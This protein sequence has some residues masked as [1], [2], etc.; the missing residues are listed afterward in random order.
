VLLLSLSLLLSVPTSK[1]KKCSYYTTSITTTR[2]QH[3]TDA[4]TISAIFTS[5][6]GEMPVTMD[7]IQEGGDRVGITNEKYNAPAHKQHMCRL[8]CCCDCGD[9]L[10]LHYII[11]S[12]LVIV[13]MCFQ[14]S[15]THMMYGGKIV[16][17]P[18]TTHVGQQQQQQQ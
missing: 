13:M 12:W 16:G 3:T 1:R 17:A 8:C 2:D 10:L 18:L 15:T 11:R 9:N 6:E 14:V 4:P 5:S 7:H